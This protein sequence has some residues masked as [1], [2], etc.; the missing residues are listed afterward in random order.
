LFEYGDSLKIKKLEN[1]T[2]HWT[3]SFR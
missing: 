1:Y 3:L 2:Q